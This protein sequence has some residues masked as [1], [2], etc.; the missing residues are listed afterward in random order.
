MGHAGLCT[1][2]I[3]LTIGSVAL[4]GAALLLSL[5]RTGTT[6]LLIVL[7][8]LGSPRWRRRRGAYALGVLYG[9]LLI[10]RAAARRGAGVRRAHLS[11][12]GGMA[13][14]YRALSAAACGG[15]KL[16][17]RVSPSKTVRR[18]RRPAGSIA[19]GVAVASYRYR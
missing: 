12:R 8:G 5:G 11:V 15:P 18:D 17:P 10:A 7:S 1:T 3:L 19:G 9:A 2:K 6:I 13:D 16:M 14:G 4:A